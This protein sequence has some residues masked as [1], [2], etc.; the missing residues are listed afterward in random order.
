MQILPRKVITDLMAVIRAAITLHRFWNA[1]A[2]R[3]KGYSSHEIIGQRFSR[4]FS[5][6][7]RAADA[8]PSS[9]L[10]DVIGA[11][12]HSKS[13]Q[14]R[15]VLSPRAGAREPGTAN[16]FNLKPFANEEAQESKP[17]RQPWPHDTGVRRG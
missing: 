15:M 16:S 6:A 5:D 1:G 7:D 2:E 3:I 13:Q 9:Y 12:K 8:C 17:S 10:R 4:F 14:S 11:P